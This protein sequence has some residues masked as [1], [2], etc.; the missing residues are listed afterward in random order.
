M[1]E[2]EEQEKRNTELRIKLLERESRKNQVGAPRERVE[3]RSREDAH[4]SVGTCVDF[5]CQRLPKT[6]MQ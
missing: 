5:A 4:V 6:R 2:Y 3:R 1:L